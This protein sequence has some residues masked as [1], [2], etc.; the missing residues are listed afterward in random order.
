MKAAYEILG[1]PTYHWVSTMENP[2]DLDL[3][4]EALAAKYDDKSCLAPYT[5]TDWDALLGHVSAVTD[6]PVNAFGPELIAAYPDA[7]VVLVERDIEK[8]AASFDENV[9]TSFSALST[10]VAAALDPG[11]LGKMGK[12]GR[13]LMHGQWG[14]RDFDDWRAKAKDGYRE[15]YALI[16]K[17]V[18]KE[19]L[20]VYQLGSGWQPLCVFLGKEV[21]DVGFPHVNE[22]EELKERVF[23]ALMLGVRRAAVRWAKMAPLALI[24]MA[25]VWSSWRL[26]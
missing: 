10:R 4:L 22:T 26:L 15:H 6:S 1:Y 11:F 18:P 17:L 20:L 5:R 23:L 19:Q 8:W 14:A 12:I 21:P 25:V 2:P 24:A 13:L 7:K 3:W 16:K 9:I